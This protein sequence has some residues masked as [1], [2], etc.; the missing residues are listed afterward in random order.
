MERCQGEN[1]GPGNDQSEQKQPGLCGISKPF[2]PIIHIA[3][4]ENS[5]EISTNPTVNRPTVKANQLNEDACRNPQLRRIATPVSACR[6]P[7]IGASQPPYR[8]VATPC[9]GASQPP[10]SAHRNPR[11][12]VSQSPYRHVAI[13]VSAC[14]NPRRGVSQP[15]VGAYSDKPTQ[16]HCTIPHKYINT[17]TPKIY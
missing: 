9:I 16:I 15:P 2:L 10:V 3:D 5:S 1:Q 11:I 6:N 7:R 12:G 13:P 8:R 4:H 14:R 17:T